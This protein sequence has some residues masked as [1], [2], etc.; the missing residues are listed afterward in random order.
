MGTEAYRRIGTVGKRQLHHGQPLL[1]R[2]SENG[3]MRWYLWQVKE[4]FVQI[5]RLYYRLCHGKMRQG[6]RV[7][8]STQYPQTVSPLPRR[9][10]VRSRADNLQLRDALGG[11][12]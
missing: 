4:H 5:K 2:R 7:I 12:M 6:N 11:W 9:E 1:K 10:P 8:R 3:F